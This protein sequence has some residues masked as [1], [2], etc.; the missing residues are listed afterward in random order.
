MSALSSALRRVALVGAAT[1]ATTLVPAGVAGAVTKGPD[2]SAAEVA[3][4]TG[5]YA[6]TETKVD[7]AASTKF[8]PA[9]VYAPKGAPGETFG[10]IA[11]SPGFLAEQWTLT[12]LAQR[13]SSFGFVTIVF[14]P[15]SIFDQPDARSRALLD[16][17]EYLKTQSTAKA[18]IDPSR[19]GVLGHSMGGGGALEAASR[20]LTLKAAVA[21]LP[22]DLT[23]N[24]SGV[25]TPTLVIGAKPDFIAPVASHAKPFYASLSTSL[26]RAYL[27]LNIGHAQPALVPTTEVS[28]AAVNWFKRFLDDDPRY[29]KTLC[30]AVAGV[31]ASTVTAYQ[32]SCGQGP[33]S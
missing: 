19:L 23:K 32:S 30:P 14:T 13:L 33:L 12:W 7:D 22:W 11:I 31:N 1:L 10:A 9:T 3:K 21:L 24:F 17:L 4:V 20:D 18:L 27:E 28:R 2:P 16:A 29:T 5:S 15:N 25:R 6:V 8:G 26:P